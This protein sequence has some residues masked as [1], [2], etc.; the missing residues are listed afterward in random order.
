MILVS[1]ILVI[2]KFNAEVLKSKFKSLHDTFR[3]IVQSEHHASGSARKD[4][5]KKWSHY[6]SMQYLHDSCLYKK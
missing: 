3:K 4:N 2:G 6:E 5:M 1:K